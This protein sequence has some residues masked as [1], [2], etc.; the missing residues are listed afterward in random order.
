MKIEVHALLHNEA[1]MIPYFIRHYQRFADIYF[2]ESN[3]TDGSVELAESLGAHV[4]P[5]PTGNELNEIRFLEMKNNCWKGSDADWVIIGDTDE[6]VYH[7]N[8]IN[9]LQSTKYTIFYPKEWRMY[10]EHFPTTPGQIYDEVQY[11]T[12]GLPGYNKMNLF[13]P[14]EIKEMNYA[15]GCHSAQPE[16]N[17]KICTDSEIVTLHFHNM[18]IDYRLKRNAY[19][20]SRLSEL[21]KQR[22]W[23]SHV[24]LSENKVKEEI[25]KEMGNLVKVI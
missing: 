13:R 22:G 23:G 16:G 2:Y 12:P 24:Q 14:S 8:L 18:G 1:P 19:F 3:S 5:F 4:I 6:L 15:V 10:S 11:G 20:A 25:E 7:P 17:V 9:I 21:N